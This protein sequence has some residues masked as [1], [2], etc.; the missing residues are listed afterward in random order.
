[1]RL[2]QSALVIALSTVMLTAGQTG[3]IA[4]RVTDSST[5]DPLIGCNVLVAG[6]NFGAATDEN[7]EYFVINLGPGSYDVEFSMIGYASYTAEGV[8]V[9][10]DVTTPVDASL[11]TEAVQLTGVTVSAE[12]PAIENT[13]T[14]SKQIVSGDLA[15]SLGV[16][17]VKD[18]VKTLPGVTEF[19]G[20]LH[21]RG[22]RSGEEAYLVDGASVVNPIM[23]GEAIPVNP[24]MVGELQMITGTFNAE[25]GQAMSGLFN[26]VLREPDP[27]V[28]M[29]VSVRTALGSDYHRETADKSEFK[30]ADVYSESMYMPETDTTYAAAVE[31]T[32]YSKGSFGDPLTIKEA[33]VGVGAGRLGYMASMRE[34]DDPGRLPGMAN[35]HS[36][37]QGKLTYQPSNNLKLSAE[38]MSMERNG[39]YDP[40]YDAEKAA[41]AAGQ[42]LVWDWI[43]ALD[44]YPRTE[45]NSTQYGLTANYVMA[46]NTNITFHYDHFDKSQTDGA[47]TSK[48]DFID[49]VNIT[50]V[51]TAGDEYSGADGPNHTR[52]LEHRANDAQVNAWFGLAN[53]YG[54]Y[55]KANERHTTIGAHLT[56]QMNNRHLVK[57]GFETRNYTLNRVGHDV[58]FGR[59][60][61]AESASGEER[62]QNQSIPNVKPTETAAY[63]QD[64]MEFRD[65]IV[66]V[67]LRYDAFNVNAD[68]GV[69]DIDN[70]GQAMWENT[71]INPFDPSQRRATET[72]SMVSPRLGVSFPVGDN[73]AFRYAYGSFFQRPTFYDLLENY[74]A[75]MDG[76]TESGYFVYIGNPNLDPQE[77]TIYEM[78]M[79]YSMPNGLKI[80]VSG[81]YKDIANLTSAQ[82]V[83]NKAFVDSGQSASSGFNTDWSP[84]DVYQ[85]THFIYKTSEHFGNVRGLELSVSKSAAQGLSGRVSYTYSIARG[86]ASDKFSA[87]S[88]TQDGST[89]TGNI[90]SMTTLDWHRPHILNGYLDYHTN[91]GGMVGRVG[92]NV[93]FT[94]QSGLPVTARSGQ[95]GASLK[96]RA[97]A[98]IDVNL[99]VDADLNLPVLRPTVYLLIENLMNRRNVVAIADPGSYFDDAS[100]YHEIAAGPTNNLMAYGP[101]MT[102]HIGIS[103]DY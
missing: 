99:R 20:E 96:E 103:I 38:F 25:Y 18:L 82:E 17:S 84:G 39:F 63:I 2:L 67:G 31:G 33:T 102:M 73:M 52:E 48:D 71:D 62:V 35:D 56:S 101:P 13:L 44:Q 36:S 91:L 60:V 64:Q 85:A 74:L 22:G 15:T 40:T 53:V 97:P 100:D 16:S 14:S 61:G 45:E 37:I 68:F 23:G 93:T 75:Q 54:H 41:G 72:K 90:L 7:G 69:W 76:G 55:F 21:L 66:N 30:D 28:N 3:K 24:H 34:Y 19:N 11:L 86:T 58:W 46:A 59:T 51:T 43:Y 89:W 1:M 87:G 10:I 81:Y 65:M 29:N 49:F 79:Q 42:L 5:G 26:T 12:R 70:N 50:E 78:G 47:K 80:D 57:A 98:T 4:G 88:L 92:G 83:F 77:T 6:T 32:D 95:G 94:A 27:G 8:V 9:N